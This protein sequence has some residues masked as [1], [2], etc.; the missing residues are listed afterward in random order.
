MRKSDKSIADHINDFLEYCEVEKGLSPVSTRNYHNFLKVF[1][2]W[3]KKVKSYSLKPHELTPERIWDYRLYLSRKKDAST[4]EFIRKTTQ[5]YYL[6]ALR[7]L[8]R[9]FADKDI[10]STPSEKIKLPKLTDQDKKIKFLSFTQVEKLLS[11]PDIFTTEGLRDRAILEVLFSTGTR[12]SELTSLNIRQLDL[13]NLLNGKFDDFELSIAGKGGSVRTIY[14]SN[15]SLKWLSRYLK[16]RKDL[17]PALFI[18]YKKGGDD[19]NHRL[20]V[21]S[22]ERLVKKYTIMAGLPVDATPHT[23][24]HSFATDLLEQ[25]ADMRS[26]QELLGHKNIVTTQIYTHITNPQLRDIHKKFHSGERLC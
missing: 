10:I 19:N 18:N 24:R 20:T 21:R 6:I 11:I 8:L 23:L 2:N 9:Y 14:F 13:K 7:N 17:S 15:R 5:S 4:G 22:V 16:T 26:V 25:G 3:L 1:S 12:V